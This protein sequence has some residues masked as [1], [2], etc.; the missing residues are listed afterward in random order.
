[1]STDKVHLSC[2]PGPLTGSV[3]PGGSKSI[4][5]RLLM[6]KYVG[7]SRKELVNISESNDTTLLKQLLSSKEQI[8]DCQ[9]AGT[10]FRFL[11]AYLAFKDKLR[12]LTGDDRML[13]RPIGPLVDALN[14]MGA[15][16]EYLEEEGY[17]P[18]LIYPARIV[19]DYYV[20]MQASTSSQFVTAILLVTPS[21][22]QNFTIK[23]NGKI[24]SDSYINMTIALMKQA[25]I[26][27]SRK[28]NSITV[29]PGKYD[30]SNISI[31]SDWSSA[32]YFYGLAALVPGSEIFIKGLQK[33]SLQGDSII[34]Y[35]MKDFGVS[36]RYT[37]QGAIISSVK[38]Q[39]PREKEFDFIS[40]P[41][42][43]QTVSVVLA[44]LGVKGIY[45]GLDTLALKETDRLHAIK[46]ELHKT[47]V[48]IIQ[49]ET[50]PGASNMPQYYI[51]EG[52]AKLNNTEFETWKDH[53]MAMSLSLFSVLGP[54]IINDPDVVN[55]SYPRFWDDLKSLGF[56]SKM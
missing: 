47:G 20:D 9:S 11:T 16:I 15:E 24:V 35:W 30:I 55:K 53:R 48:N 2:T 29:K 21:F 17:P 7:R 45:S 6:M 27:V 56:I 41:D 33:D 44:V 5:N 42:L 23:M 22:V 31:E 8:L 46:E 18:L 12:I 50:G 43:F 19:W 14:M 32:S 39:L 49:L 4:S 3:N 51:Q 26:K 40:T 10:T 28:A 1:M 52:K 37:E 34:A 36:T 38:I 13:Q 25:G 54:V